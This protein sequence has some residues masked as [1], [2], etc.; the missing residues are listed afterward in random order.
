MTFPYL[1]NKLF[2]NLL[3]REIKNNFILKDIYF[4]KLGI[5]DWGLGIGD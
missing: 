3:Y 1:I 5:R 4:I 2:I